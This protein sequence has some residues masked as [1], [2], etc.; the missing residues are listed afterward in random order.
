MAVVRSCSGQSVGSYSHHLG[1]P[2][3]RQHIA[4]YIENRDGIP[5]NVDDIFIIGGIASA[6]PDV[7]NLLA[8]DDKKIG[9]HF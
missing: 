7:V 6:I 1:I 3:V 2:I 5:A 8:R 9:N 4:E